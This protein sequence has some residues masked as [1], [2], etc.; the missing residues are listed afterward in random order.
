M[1]KG[2]NM[3]GII[4]TLLLLM[5][6]GPAWGQCT[7][8]IKDVL[9]DDL[10][11]SILVKTQYSLNGVIV[12]VRGKPDANALGET[13]YTENDGTL[14]EIVDKIK[15]DLQSHCSALMVNQSI[16]LNNLKVAKKQVQES[17]VSPMIETLRNNAI[18]WTKSINST[19][20]TFKNKEI[21][22][23]ADGSYTVS[24]IVE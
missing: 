16:K 13:R 23:N 14:Q 11:G 9:I 10:T 20:F 3:R 15:V 24:D 17:L 7:V 5:V 2:L 19:S 18:G 8:E 1:D 22:V 21:T 12:D 4:L 6:T